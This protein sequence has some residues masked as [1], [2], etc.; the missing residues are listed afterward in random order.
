[1]RHHTPVDLIP[2]TS[3]VKAWEITANIKGIPVLCSAAEAPA[4][5]GQAILIDGLHINKRVRLYRKTNEMIGF[6]REHGASLDLSM[7][8]IPSILKV[9]DAVHGN[10]P[11][12]HY[13]KEATVAVVGALRGDQYQ[14]LPVMLSPTCKSENAEQFAVVVQLLIDQWKEHGAAVHGPLWHISTDGDATF[15]GALHLVL[16][17]QEV[18]PGALRDRLCQL[19]GLNLRTGDD[20]IVWNPDHRHLVKRVA[21]LMRSHE[22]MLLSQVVMNRRL[23]TQELTRLPQHDSKAVE[24][25]LDPNDHQN[26]PKAVQL[27]QAI[28]VLSNIKHPSPS[29]T[30][31]DT[32]R[33]LTL[34]GDLWTSFLNLYIS[35]RWSLSEQLISLSKVAHLL[36]ALF[37]AHGTAFMTGQLYG[38]IQAMIKSTYFG[39]AKQQLLDGDK[40]YYLCQEGSNRLE[41]YFGQVRTATHDSNC[42][43]LELRERLCSVADIADILSRHP[44][45]DRGHR[46]LSYDGKEG[47]DRVNPPY[48]TGDLV[49]K[50]AHLAT[51]WKSGRVQATE[52]LQQA[53]MPFDFEAALS[54]TVDFLRPHGG[55]KYPGRSAGK[56]RSMP[57]DHVPEATAD[58]P[59]HD[60]DGNP[61]SHA[62]PIRLPPEDG[63]DMALGDLLSEPDEDGNVQAS[64]KR[65]EDWIE[66]T[67]KKGKI[68]MLHKASV[69]S[70]IFQIGY[71]P[72]CVDRLLR[73]RTYMKDFIKVSVEEEEEQATVRTLSVGSIAV[74]LIRCEGTI[75]LA[76][77]R[78]IALDK[79]NTHVGQV[80]ECDLVNANANVWAQVQVCRMVE[81][82][83]HTRTMVAGQEMEEED[84]AVAE[85]S[86]AWIWSGE[87]V[88]FPPAKGSRARLNEG[89]RKSLVIKLPGLFLRPLNPSTVLTSEVRSVS[90]R[91]VLLDRSIA[92]TWSLTGAE[93]L[94]LI[95]LI[96]D[97][98]SGANAISLLPTYG[99][100]R[101][102]PYRDLQG[103][104]LLTSQQTPDQSGCHQ[105]ASVLNVKTCEN[106]RAHVGKHI[107]RAKYGVAE[108]GLK[109]QVSFCITGRSYPCGFCGRGTC[110]IVLL[111]K[112]KSMQVES[113]CARAHKFSYG[114]AI[115]T[116]RT[117]PSTNVPV[118]CT[119]CPRD[120]ATKRHPT[121]WKYN[122]RDHIKIEHS[123]HWEGLLDEPIGLDSELALSIRIEAEEFQ[124][125]QVPCPRNIVPGV[126]GSERKATSATS[127]LSRSTKRRG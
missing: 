26:V 50:N 103:E 29:P 54:G 5:C 84:E 20:D 116:N 72:L 119:L 111:A 108:P 67:D 25:L 112:G 60:P 117:T 90:P 122:M 101:Q 44:K 106:P 28:Q 18:Q 63:I 8:D 110:T 76:L 88:S 69:L 4:L 15:C 62:L 10:E 121:F 17:K 115:K 97:T 109:E 56:D 95:S 19:E 32:Q 36:F 64:D 6:C 94:D 113:N 30:D 80:T 105:C 99:E 66:Y 100:S 93:I 9:A 123:S 104:P 14:P 22:G 98:E 75:A 71:S 65:G 41:V 2:S 53:G 27:L 35:P 85:T 23:L 38:D 42:D 31:M 102:F 114:Q 68:H 61:E 74:A 21:T 124:Y 96:F 55:D 48:F 81:S 12:C 83:I 89:S 127:A 126:A 46:R 118:F 82:M 43:A 1:M 34:L 45:W 125:I 70:V 91:D 92:Q 47:V 33:I 86:P 120:P 11:T 24:L 58:A 59:P 16:M 73:V 7:H 51:A 57:D 37:R 77:V 49:A 13:G 52:T 87:Y 40:P 78:V 3:S 79:K 107:L 39:V